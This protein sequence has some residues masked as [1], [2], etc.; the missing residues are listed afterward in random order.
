VVQSRYPCGSP[1]IFDRWL[2]LA[3]RDGYQRLL[4]R[5]QARLPKPIVQRDLIEGNWRECITADS[6]SAELPI[7][8]RRTPGERGQE[9]ANGSIQSLV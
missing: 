2:Y 3:K 7:G 4:L 6:I 9:T 1:Q 5:K 8:R